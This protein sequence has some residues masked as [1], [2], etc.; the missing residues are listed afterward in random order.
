MNDFIC[1]SFFVQFLWIN[2]GEWICRRGNIFFVGFTHAVK[3]S[4]TCLMLISHM[5]N[6]HILSIF[7]FFG[8]RNRDTETQ[9]TVND[10]NHLKVCAKSLKFDKLV[11]KCES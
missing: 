6:I 1:L 11:L 9:R 8:E 3:I 4:A 7:P 5:P 10:E 2:F